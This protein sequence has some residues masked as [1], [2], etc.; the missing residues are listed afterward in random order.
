M[1]LFSWDNSFSA[2]LVVTAS[3]VSSSFVTSAVAGV[4]VGFGSIDGFILVAIRGVG[5]GLVAL[6]EGPGFGLALMED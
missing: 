1:L 4:D 5:R 6:V 2:L 3:I